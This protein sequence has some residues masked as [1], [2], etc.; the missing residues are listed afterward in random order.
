MSTVPHAL[1]PT[2]RFALAFSWAFRTLFDRVI[3]AALFGFVAAG[4][5]SLLVQ[6]LGQAPAADTG[7]ALM[8][9]RLD[10]AHQAVASV[11]LVLVTG[12]CL[13]RRSPRAQRAGLLPILV[14]L[15]GTFT[16]AFPATQARVTDDSAVLTGANLLLIVGLTYTVYAVGSLGAC[17]GLAAEARGLVTGG[18]YRHVRHPVYLGELIAA[19]GVLWPVLTPIT[20]AAFVLFLV[21]QGYRMHLEERVLSAAFPEYGSYRQSVPMLLPWP[22]PAR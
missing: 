22:R 7:Q 5:I 11:F 18:A 15:A 8:V 16:M 3:P 1:P 10:V 2:I 19:L 9:Y 12:L 6:R 13:T 21:L 14:A 4:R 20:G 17:F